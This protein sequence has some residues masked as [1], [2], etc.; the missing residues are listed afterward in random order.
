MLKCGHMKWTSTR[1]GVLEKVEGRGDEK[2][3]NFVDLSFRDSPTYQ[4][5]MQCDLTVETNEIF[6][7]GR[8]SQAVTLSSLECL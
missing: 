6:S 1:E 2:H 5:N 3:H 8:S 4:H 7:N